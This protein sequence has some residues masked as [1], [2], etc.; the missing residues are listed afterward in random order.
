LLLQ[1]LSSLPPKVFLYSYSRKSVL[2]NG[3]LTQSATIP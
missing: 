2:W 1:S 3:I